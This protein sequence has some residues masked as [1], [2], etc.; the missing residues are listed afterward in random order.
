ML[1]SSWGDR[2]FQERKLDMARRR[3][4]K[5]EKIR[6]VLEQMGHDAR[7]RDVVATL[8]ARRIKVTPAQ[9]SNVRA[10]MEAGGANA[11]PGNGKFGVSIVALLDA[12]KLVD[13]VGSLAA[14]RQT[15]DA[16]AKLL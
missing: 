9:V 2:S 6:E 15:L 8:K 7:P 5:S 12:K 10:R 4:N 3:I 14:A 1:N 16:L 11:K 13:E